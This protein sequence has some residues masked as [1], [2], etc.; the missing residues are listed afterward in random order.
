VYE[1]NEPFDAY[2]FKVDVQMG[3]YSGNTFYKMQL[4]KEQI[5]GV[6]ILFTRWGRVG[7]QGQY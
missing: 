4:L 5:R 2:M 6:Y 7:D 3:M 1:G